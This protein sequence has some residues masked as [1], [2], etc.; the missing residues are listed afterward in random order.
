MGII[1]SPEI[2][3]EIEK[4]RR[5]IERSLSFLRGFLR[6]NEQV[7]LRIVVT[8]ERVTLSDNVVIEVNDSIPCDRLPE[9]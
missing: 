1:R 6:K 2:G 8:A 4:N 7:T 3:E 5:R 9:P